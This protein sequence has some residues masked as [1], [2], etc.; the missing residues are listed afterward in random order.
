MPSTILITAI[1]FLLVGYFFGWHQ[2][3]Q[4]QVDSTT[5][6]LN[7][8]AFNEALALAAESAAARWTESS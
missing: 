1:L 7:K 4:T 2:R 5:G 8:K 3:G 6:L